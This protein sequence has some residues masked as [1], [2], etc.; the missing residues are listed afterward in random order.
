MQQIKYKKKKGFHGIS[1]SLDKFFFRN[2]VLII[3]GVFIWRGMW[4]LIDLSGQNFFNYGDY[5]NFLNSN[6]F[7]ADH[8]F[9]IIIGLVM[10]YLV[11]THLEPPFEEEN[12]S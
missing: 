5:A 10:M 9:S 8:V 6:L 2:L 11:D 1:M 7:I 3:S 12:R 4:G